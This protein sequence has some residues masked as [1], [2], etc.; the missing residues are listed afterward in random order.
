MALRRSSG[1]HKRIG[2]KHEGLKLYGGEY[3]GKHLLNA[4]DM[5]VTNSEQG[6]E[7]RLIGF[8]AIVPSCYGS[9]GLFSHHIYR[10][11]P[12][13]EN[14]LD[15]AANYTPAGGH[16]TVSVE[17]RGDQAVVRVRDTGVGIPPEFLPHVFEPFT[18]EDNPAV[19]EQPGSGIGLLAVRRIVELHGGCVEVASR[20]R[21]T[22][23][24][25]TV[26]LPL[27]TNSGTA[28]GGGVAG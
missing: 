23:T 3:R 20:G 4:G 14:L 5:I 1:T 6:H 17:R 16:V 22:G 26:R 15:N 24:E 11:R 27:F 9:T 18:R 2:Y 19:R 21:G 25:F 7:H 8:P 12:L 13:L 10:I 28:P